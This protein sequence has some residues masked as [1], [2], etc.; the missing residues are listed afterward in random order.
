MR[1]ATVLFE[2]DG[3]RVETPPTGEYWIAPSAIVVGRVKL[4]RDVSIWFGSVLRGDNELIHIK[5]RSNIQDGCILHTD[6]GFPLTVGQGCVIGHRATLHGC[7]IGMNSLI[8]IGATIL[9]GCRIGD[10][11]IVG[12]HALI[13]EGK[14]IPAGSLVMGAPGRVVREVTA[15]EVATLTEF[16]ADVYAQNWKRFAK[17]L[18]AMEDPKRPDSDA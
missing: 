7:S 8:G 16:G 11:C 3:A 6:P 14:E 2:L 5:E 18:H 4:E 1:I 13:T 9:N 12:A 15:Q 17:G 10:N